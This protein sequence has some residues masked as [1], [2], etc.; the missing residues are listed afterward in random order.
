MAYDLVVVGMCAVAVPLALALGMQ[1]G[2]RVPRRVLGSLAGIGTGL[3]VLRAVASL[4]QT[5]YLLVTGQFVLRQMGIW[6]PWFYMGAILFGSNLWSYW[7][8]PRSA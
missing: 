6:E 3:L 8:R 7:R 4:I 2:R 1:W 5:A